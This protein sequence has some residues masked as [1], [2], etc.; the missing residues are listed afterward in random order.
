MAQF[1]DRNSGFFGANSTGGGGGACPIVILGAGS[2]STL[3]CGS[4]NTATGDYTTAF[5]RDNAASFN[6]STIGG[7]QCNIA[8]GDC[9][10]S[11]IS[12][13]YKNTAS[14][15][16][17]G[18]YVGGG[19][20]NCAYGQESVVSG[21]LCNSAGGQ[22]SVISGGLRNV[23]NGELSNIGG[24]ICNTSSSYR[25]VVSGGNTNTASGGEST[26]SGGVLNTASGYFSTVSG[27][28]INTASAYY[29]TISGGKENCVSG[30]LG[31]ASG[32][33]SNSVIGSASV[34]SGGSS[35]TNWG[36]CSVVS[37]GL[38][39]TIFS[40]NQSVGGTG[41][42][43]CAANSFIGGGA[44]NYINHSI[45]SASTYIAAN[46]HNSI[47]GGYNNYVGATLSGGGSN[48]ISGFST[49]SGG[50]NNTIG[51]RG[52]VSGFYSCST[53][54]GGYQNCISEKSVTISGGYFNTGSGYN[55]TI[56]GGSFNNASGT[57]S[58]ISGGYENTASN[59][60]STIGGGCQNISS[61]C[62]STI[63]GGYANTSSGNVS[64]I[65]G[66][67]SNSASAIYSSIIGGRFGLAYLYGQT[68]NA[69]G[70]F[71]ALGDSQISNLVARKSA[72]LTTAATSILSLDG[73]G[74]TNLIIPS[75]SNRLWNV[76]VQYGAVV[77]SK[78]GTATGV[79][80][81]DVKTHIDLFNYK[82]VGGVGTVSTITSAANHNDASMATADMTYAN[83]AGSLQVTFVAP[84]FTG[85][86][87][88]TFRTT[89][90]IQLTEVAW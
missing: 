34:I 17:G 1:G 12:G 42:V 15:Y 69:S 53:I 29:T 22:T 63:G 13:G 70:E 61:G 71:A 56:G 50:G 87:T 81:G 62:C 38:Q 82:L 16:Y 58:V 75:G 23:S 31:T 19:R 85:G 79:N 55:S 60:K 7:G 78:T 45:G 36:D 27:G 28:R 33:Y 30:I 11:T 72:A 67:Y 25:S 66:G 65:T 48:F 39:N 88:V 57:Y 43:F 51:S 26:V 74:T 5:G 6:Y 59:N 83:N 46:G 73:T 20:C 40:C 9:G 47:S 32:G 14:N 77:V 90:R 41:I 86:G 21:G 89:A 8:S 4:A 2:C 52:G 35:N 68:S 10:Y 24:G 64:T 84:T 54:S 37:G 80:I 3:R 76:L 18:A 44:L 49:I